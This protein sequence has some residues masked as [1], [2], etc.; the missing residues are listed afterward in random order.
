MTERKRSGPRADVDWF[1]IRRAF[2]SDRYS[3]EEIA[4][5]MGVAGTS[6]ARRAKKEGWVR[7][8]LNAVLAKATEEELTK[9]VG[10]R[11]LTPEAVEEAVKNTAEVIK[12]HRLVSRAGRSLVATLMNQLLDASE[13]REEIEDEVIR[14]TMGDRDLNKRQRMLDAVSLPGHANTLKT[15]SVAAANFI[16]LERE[17]FGLDS[18]KPGESGDADEPYDPTKEVPSDAYRRMVG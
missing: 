12:T 15:L 6:I 9:R 17:S 14:E 4:A 13:K 16:K 18:L 5:R 10:D 1:I 7:G 8:G 3:M 2:E 11:I